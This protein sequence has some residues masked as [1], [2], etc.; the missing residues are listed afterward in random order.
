M[1]TRDYD[2]PRYLVQYEINEEVRDVI[3]TDDYK[4]AKRMYDSIIT[5]YN[6]INTPIKARIHDYSKEAD[7][8][9]YDTESEIC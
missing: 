4:D 2:I 1:S 8:E 3:A 5:K 9:T 6:K 7:I